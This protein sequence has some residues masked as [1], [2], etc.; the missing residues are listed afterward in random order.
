MDG[1]AG[2]GV[3][4]SASIR[5]S[6]PADRDAS[7][8]SD[9][10]VPTCTRAPLLHREDAAARA[11]DHNRPPGDMRPQPIPE[12]TPTNCASDADCN[13]GENGRCI[14]EFIYYVC[15]YDQCFSDSDCMSGG[16]CGCS[17]GDRYSDANICLQGDCRIDADCGPGGYCSPS[18]SACGNLDGYFCHTCTDECVDD[19]DCPELSDRH[20]LC[21]YSSEAGHWICGSL[22]QCP[23]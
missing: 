20:R 4:N 16:P 13:A 15:T 6:D 11:C 10:R 21:V 5:S 19:A 7:A 22:M 12:G 2:R 14:A 8:T 1:E 23:D 3:G 9:Q 17:V 18:H